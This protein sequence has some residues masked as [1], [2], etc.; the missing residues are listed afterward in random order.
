MNVFVQTCKFSPENTHRDV[1]ILATAP[2][3]RE[4]SELIANPFDYDWL[5]I[6]KFFGILLYKSF[7][8]VLK[9]IFSSRILSLLWVLCEF[10]LGDLLL[11]D[12]FGFLDNFRSLTD[13]FEVI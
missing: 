6:V 7:K 13:K 1:S 11:F 2:T 10:E 9:D 5:R 3:F 8:E 12:L 4:K